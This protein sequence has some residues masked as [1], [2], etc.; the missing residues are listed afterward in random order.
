[1]LIGAQHFYDI[2]CAE[3]IKP[4]SSGPIFQKTR[5]GW[6]ISGPVLQQSHSFVVNCTNC[7]VEPLDDLLTRFWRVE[8]FDN[9]ITHALEEKQCKVLFDRTV[10]RGDDGRLIVKLP[11]KDSVL[12]LGP[13][14]DIALRRFLSLEKR[15]Q[16]D[17]IL[18]TDCVQFLK[19]Y[20]LLGHME[21]VTNVNF[22]SASKSYYIPHH[23]VRNPNSS[24]TKLRVVFDASC[25]TQSGLSLNEVLLKGPVVQ[26]DL[27]YILAR[28]R[29]YKVVLTGDIAKMYRQVWVTHEHQDF[30]RI[31]WRPE[32]DQP[33]R[34]YRLKTVTYGTVPAS[35]LSTA[36]LNKLAEDNVDKYPAA[37]EAILNNFYV[38]DFLG[39]SDTFENAARLKEEMC[40]VLNKAGFEL[41]K[42]SSN[43]P[44]LISQ[45]QVNNDNSHI[46]ANNDGP[47][48]KVLEL[49]WNAYSDTLQYIVKNI[50]ISGSITK[51][52]ILSHIASIYDPLGLLGPIIVQGKFIMQNLWQQQL[53]WDEP[54]PVNIKNDWEAYVKKLGYINKIIIPR[55]IIGEQKIVEYQVHGFSDSSIRAYG[56]ALYLRTTNEHG[57]HTVRLI[58]AK[59][60]VAPIKT[61]SLPRLELCAA[62]LLARLA[63][64]VVKNLQIANCK[65]FLYTDSN[66]VLAWISSSSA[67]WKTFVAH[68]VGE[69]QEITSRAEWAHVK[70]Q[71]NPADVISRGS[72]PKELSKSSLWWS[73]PQW[74]QKDCKEWQT[75]A[76]A[77]SNLNLPEVKCTE[78]YNS[79]NLVANTTRE[80]FSL[81]NRCSNY[82]KILRVTAYCYRFIYNAGRKSDRKIASL[83][84]S[85][86]SQA[87]LGL[88][89][90]VQ[91]DYFSSEIKN[92]NHPT[93]FV[94]SK[95][96]LFRLR[97][98]MNENGVLRVGGR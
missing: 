86:L 3:K 79:I 4:N 83:E 15:L 6:V 50:S 73:G 68:R 84:V 53:E 59:S 92:L 62:L 85:E 67:K 60:K 74:L 46:I 27:L 87:N 35:F 12:K 95:S 18:K 37:S 34:T 49:V 97:P 26:D 81:L 94:S 45:L 33:I 24:T 30:Q 42:W 80:N 61:V 91:N 23:A 82:Q 47:I 9:R 29:K 90:H 8:E 2:L 19:E 77:I 51:H 20:E 13:S 71:D 1:M 40:T 54:V 48:T 65:R 52:S 11:F 56:A 17:S 88:I 14:Y 70:S 28:F 36:C 44:N 38:D 7:E 58:C 78:K 63:Q 66:I 75:T 98:Y 43:E 93:P 10:R 89:K 39:G 76:E 64:K 55:K 31:L 69:I 41:R 32:P 21:L 96:P 72:Y 25:K 22:I 57:Q 5:F 16:N